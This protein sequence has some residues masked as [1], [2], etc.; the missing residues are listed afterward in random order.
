MRH[1]VALGRL[2]LAGVLLIPFGGRRADAHDSDLFPACEPWAHRYERDC[3]MAGW[4]TEARFWEDADRRAYDR[5]A[6]ALDVVCTEIAEAAR[7]ACPF[8]NQLPRTS[9]YKQWQRVWTEDQ[10]RRA[11][12]RERP[13]AACPRRRGCS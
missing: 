2:L 1:R 3:L 5:R 13:T 12:E 9:E 6:D 10:E 7:L 11:W 4:E 8:W